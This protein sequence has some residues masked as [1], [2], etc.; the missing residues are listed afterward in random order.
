MNKKKQNG[1]FFNYLFL[2]YEF[3]ARASSD[4]PL[5][6]NTCEFIDQPE[7]R[8]QILLGQRQTEIAFC[9]SPAHV[10][11]FQKE[12]HC[13][14][15][16]STCRVLKVLSIQWPMRKKTKKKDAASFRLWLKLYV[17]VDKN[18]CTGGTV[19]SW[20]HVPS[21]IFYCLRIRRRIFVRQNVE[22]NT[23]IS[24]TEGSRKPPSKY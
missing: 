11:T 24:I 18:S 6:D 15:I 8:F 2:Q 20:A 12:S 23:L 1:I 9:L 17:F 16:L 13:D 10:S 14:S 5:D 21:C 22:N 19:T 7:A 4:F 3:V